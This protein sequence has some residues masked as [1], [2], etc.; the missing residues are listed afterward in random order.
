MAAYLFQEL[1][2]MTSDEF[3]MN[4]KSM[5]DLYIKEQGD[6]VTR[7]RELAQEQVRVSP[8]K[9]LIDSERTKRL[10][11]G[12]MYMMQYK[13]KD[14][15]KLIYYDRFPVFMCL[16]VHK[17]WFTGLNFHYLPP[18]LRA[19][20]LNEL[21]PFVMAPEV[22]ADDMARSLRVKLSPRV[23]YEFMKKRRSMMSFKPMWKRYRRD[24]VLGQFAYMP[25]IA[26]DIITMLPVQQFRKSSINRVWID[27][28]IKR[29]KKN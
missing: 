2:Q 9:M 4:F 6:P 17:E 8:Q 23:D 20:L 13:P 22:K 27:S 21:Y 12:R 16:N 26:W 25:P 24:S 3:G 28:Q 14:I 1:A 29:R 11:P 7:L 10:L 15:N 19:E 18:E 5:K